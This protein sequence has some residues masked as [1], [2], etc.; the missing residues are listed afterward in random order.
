MASGRLRS[1]SFIVSK[2]KSRHGFFFEEGK[3][4]LILTG[5]YPKLLTFRDTEDHYNNTT[6]H[7]AIIVYDNEWNISDVWFENPT[8]SLPYPTLLQGPQLYKLL[9]KNLEFQNHRFLS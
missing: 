6:I 5:T 3:M 1:S 2:N 7:Y 8:S 9:R 4:K